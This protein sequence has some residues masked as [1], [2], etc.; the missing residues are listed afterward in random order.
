MVGS[1]FGVAL[2]KNSVFHLEG[3]ALYDLTDN[4]STITA[5]IGFSFL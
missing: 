4:Y 1:A 2:G 5:G 3:V